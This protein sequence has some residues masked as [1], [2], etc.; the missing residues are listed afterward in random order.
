MTPDERY[1]LALGMLVAYVGP[2]ERR[3]GDLHFLADEAP[4]SDVVAGLLSLAKQLLALAA[5]ASG[6]QP[7]ELL[8]TIA[9]SD[10][11]LG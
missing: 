1:R 3:L 2:E 8:R 5:D 4:V 9:E 7:A 11:D 10:L 6:F